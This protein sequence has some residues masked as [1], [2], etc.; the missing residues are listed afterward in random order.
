MSRPSATWSTDR[1]GLARLALAGGWNADSAADV[2]AIILALEPPPGLAHAIEINCAEILQLDTIGAYLV[3]DLRRKIGPI[4][5]I[6][7]AGLRPDQ[8]LLLSEVDFVPS[9]IA[10]RIANGG[11]YQMLTDV[12]EAVVHA[13]RDFSDGVAFLGRVV[14]VFGRVMTGQTRFRM[15]A[16]VAQ[17]ERVALRSVPIIVLISFLVGAI[18][19]QQLATMRKTEIH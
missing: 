4:L 7:V 1:A 17:L 13:G 16:V 10:P 9:R 8:E 14:A 11:A 15:T 18:I 3:H 2:E 19:A 12:G 6:K 5:P